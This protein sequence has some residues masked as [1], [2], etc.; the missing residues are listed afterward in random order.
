MIRTYQLIL[1]TLVASCSTSSDAVYTNHDFTAA[2]IDAESSRATVSRP[3]PVPIDNKRIDLA[4]RAAMKKFSRSEEMKGLFNAPS[5]EFRQDYDSGT[6]PPDHRLTL[7][8]LLW[9]GY[10]TSPMID[11]A[12]KTL[13]AAFE[14]YDQV[15]FLDDIVSR[16][17]SFITTTP[18]PSTGARAAAGSR[19]APAMKAPYP[20]LDALRGDLADLATAAAW[21]K[22]TEVIAMQTR[23]LT[24]M[25]AELAY[26]VAL[27]QAVVEHLVLVKRLVTVV[28]TQLA[29]GRT[30]QADLLVIQSE[31]KSLQTQ[32]A[33]LARS[34][35]AQTA[36]LNIE[37]KRDA[38]T[39]LTLAPLP[40]PASAVDTDRILTLVKTSDAVT[41]RLRLQTKRA[42]T[43]LR[44][45]ERMAL[46]SIDTSAGDVRLGQLGSAS[47]ARSTMLI[48]PTGRVPNRSRGN[49]PTQALLNAM[50]QKMQAKHETAEA[51]VVEASHKLSLAQSSQQGALD[52]LKVQQEQIIPLAR[53]AAKSIERSY[54]SRKGSFL[55]MHRAATRLIRATTDAARFRR[56]AI[57]FTAE[58]RALLARSS[59]EMK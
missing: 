41:R 29:S 19:K 46:A 39:P 25:A 53:S 10:R 36:A 58:I 47:A 44:L 13:S 18:P 7:D 54:A 38:K 11:S 43:A 24:R 59:G 9:V 31:L 21:E 55:D 14:G 1:L 37:L 8:E 6:L 57:C 23:K 27:E 5:E 45:A 56:D 52:L 26:T 3:A 22:L 15:R 12:R 34:R 33:N 16:Y 42:A 30:R 2:R 28:Q 17:R 48:Q 35:G 40:T 51:R 4:R 50:R 49:G 32:R 20:A